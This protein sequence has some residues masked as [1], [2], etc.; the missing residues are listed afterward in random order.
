MKKMFLLCFCIIILVTFV[1]GCRKNSP[2]LVSNDDILELLAIKELDCEVIE[3]NLETESDGY[4]TIFAELYVSEEEFLSNQYFQ[5][6]E[7]DL[8]PLI[9]NDLIDYGIQ[10]TSITDHGINFKEFVIKKKNQTEYRPYYVYWYRLEESQKSKSNVLL[11]TFIPDEISLI[12]E[13]S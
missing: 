5:N 11:Y 3:I 10:T 12:E 4:T 8:A 6:K 9:A 2:K 13:T 7:R 1:G